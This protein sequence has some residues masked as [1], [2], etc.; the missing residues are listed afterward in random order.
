MQLNVREIYTEYNPCTDTCL[1]LIQQ[2]FPNARVTYSF[3]W[4]LWGRQTPDR[5]AAVDALFAA[6][7]QQK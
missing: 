5:N 6:Q 4:E 2:K 3:V 7:P 1:P